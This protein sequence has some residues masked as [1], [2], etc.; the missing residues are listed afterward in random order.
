MQFGA[1]FDIGFSVE[2]ELDNW[3]SDDWYDYAD[4]SYYSDYDE[5]SVTE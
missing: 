4:D 3:D 1:S 5:E 2:F